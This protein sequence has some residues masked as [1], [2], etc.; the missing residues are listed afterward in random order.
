MHV[1]H[2]AFF[3][4]HPPS[5]QNHGLQTLVNKRLNS[6]LPIHLEQIVTWSSHGPHS[7]FKGSTHNLWPSTSAQESPGFQPRQP[8]TKADNWLPAA[9]LAA[10]ETDIIMHISEHCKI[11]EQGAQPTQ[12]QGRVFPVDHLL[13]VA[14]RGGK[15]IMSL[16]PFLMKPSISSQEPLWP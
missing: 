15:D 10:E 3:Q 1:S 7:D 11:H 6:G 14:L 2:P 5:P 12:L 16:I 9:A 4:Y 8:N 13:R